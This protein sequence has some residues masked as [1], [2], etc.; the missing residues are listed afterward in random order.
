M[1]T[2]IRGLSAEVPWRAADAI[3][4]ATAL[5]AGETE[6]WTNHRHLLAAATHFGLVG[7]SVAGAEGLRLLSEPAELPGVPKDRLS[8]K[9]EIPR[10]HPLQF[11]C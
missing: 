2:L 11:S 4:L 5:E 7:K 8:K 1:A 6:I 9:T 10:L 3:H